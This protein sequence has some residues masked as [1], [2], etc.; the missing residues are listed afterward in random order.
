MKMIEIAIDGQK[1][2][3]EERSTI[4]DAAKRLG[5]WI[6]T[7]CHHDALSSQGACR[8]CIVEIERPNGRKKVV[9]ACNF[10]I[11]EPIKVETANEKIQ[12]ERR[13]IVELLL[14][15]CPNTPAI[16]DLAAKLGIEAPRFEKDDKYCILC[17]LC[18]RVCAEVIG[19]SAI[20]FVNRGIEEGVDTPFGVQSDACIGC[21]ACAYLCP[22]GII[23]V[24]DSSGVRKI[25]RWHAEFE[26]AHCTECGKPITTKKHIEYLKEKMNLPDYVWELCDECK[27]RYYM[28]NVA[29]VGHM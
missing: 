2:E 12:K 3:V 6:P 26:L 17:G 7:L 29:L 11:E 27:R 10:P 21:G 15:R 13:M 9:T 28:E 19:R 22:T 20:E 16:L 24:D 4:L 23:Y 14:A 5:I 18:V 8:S 1:I 25:K